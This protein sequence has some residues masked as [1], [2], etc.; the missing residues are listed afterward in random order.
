MV[1][2]R[3]KRIVSSCYIVYIHTSV[4]VEEE[5]TNKHLDKSVSCCISAST[6]VQCLWCIFQ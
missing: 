3:E 5:L 2:S 6:F 4:V 1:K